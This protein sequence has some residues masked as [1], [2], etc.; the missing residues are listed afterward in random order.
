MNYVNHV[1]SFYTLDC[2]LESCDTGCGDM[3]MD[4]LTDSGGTFQSK[5]YPLQLPP[6]TTCTWTI[7]APAGKFIYVKFNDFEVVRHDATGECEDFIQLQE[8]GQS[9]GERERQICG[10]PPPFFLSSTN[11]LLVVYRTGL[12]VRSLGFSANYKTSGK[13]M[14]LSLY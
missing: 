9:L 2:R 10:T 4:V 11:A 12:D 8:E 5:G 7:S 6:F 3:A 13:H 1:N 14:L